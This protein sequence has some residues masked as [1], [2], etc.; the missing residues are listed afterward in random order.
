MIFIVL[1]YA[2]L[3]FTLTLSKL[4]LAHVSPIFLV[5]IRMLL[6]GVCLLGYAYNQQFSYRTIAR[7]DWLLI[8]QLGLWGVMVP[9][10]SRSWA[11]QYVPTVKAA[12]IFNLAPF[13]SALFGY[14]LIRE[15]LT[16]LQTAGLLIG[17]AGLVPL[18]LKNAPTSS[19]LD[20]FTHLALP[21]LVLLLAVASLS[22]SF[23]ITQHLVRHRNC[24]LVVANAF[25]MLIGGFLA[26]NAAIAFEPAWF[27]GS[28]VVF[29]PLF[30]LNVIMSNFFCANMQAWL[31]KK[32]SSTFISFASFLSPPFAA[33][34]SWLL[35]N[36]QLSPTIFI[37]FVFVLTGLGLYFYDSLRSKQAP[38]TSLEKTS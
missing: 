23:F 38:A 14:I 1:L 22:Y 30:I 17:F 12:L 24:S 33:L 36:E 29:I 11:L 3:G 34:Y 13:F 9:H 15:R 35:L 8:F 4:L 19:P 20:L 31:L 27:K 32:H 21:D 18:F 26:F 37:A 6:A 2:T 5:G 25:S 16:I 7:Q 28:I 10:V